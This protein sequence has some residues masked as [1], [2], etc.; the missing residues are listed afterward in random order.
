MSTA[1]KR[2]MDEVDMRRVIFRGAL[3]HNPQSIHFGHSLES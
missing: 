2:I 3:L 1:V